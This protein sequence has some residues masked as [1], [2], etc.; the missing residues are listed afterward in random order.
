MTARGEQFVSRSHDWEWGEGRGR[1]TWE[2][3]VTTAL[4]AGVVPAVSSLRC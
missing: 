2:D 1:G 3:L 4:I